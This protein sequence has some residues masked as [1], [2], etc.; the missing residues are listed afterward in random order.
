MTNQTPQEPTPEATPGQPDTAAAAIPPEQHQYPAP[1]TYPAPAQPQHP[2]PSAYPAPGQAPA[3]A[4]AP[5]PSLYS[6]AE[7]PAPGQP[8]HPAPQPPQGPVAPPTN[9]LAI[10]ALILG[11]VCAPAAIVTGHIALGKI[12]RSGESGRGLALAGTILGYVFTG[13]A[14]IGTAIALIISATLGVAAV[15]AAGA[16]LQQLDDY[17]DYVAPEPSTEAPSGAVLDTPEKILEVWQPC[18]LAT[19]LDSDSGSAFYDDREWV[20]AQEALARL[21]DPSAESEAIRN[22]S[23]HIISNGT[24]DFEMTAQYVDALEASTAKLCAQ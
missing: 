23:A 13:L 14:V 20:A 10:I 12:K 1:S 11:F 5:A 9:T 18:E 17:S 4:P 2:A 16:G 15:S 7:Q 19:E 6:Y 22:Y 3:P 8:M 24:F 21:M